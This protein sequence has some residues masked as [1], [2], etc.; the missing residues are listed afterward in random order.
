MAE[1]LRPHRLEV[2]SA[3]SRQ[4][5]RR[6]NKGTSKPPPSL[7]ATVPHHLLDVIE[8]TG[9]FSAAEFARLAKQTAQEIRERGAVPL[10]VGGAMFYVRTLL[11]GPPATPPSDPQVRQRLA[12]RVE[13]EG[14][15]A[16]YDE[17]AVVDPPTAERL[18]QNDR[19]RILRA[20]E[21]YI[22]SGRPL[23]AFAV[24][25]APDAAVA[26][27]VLGVRRDRAD[28]Y[29]RIDERV[30]KMVAGDLVAEI[31]SLVAAGFSADNPG[32]QSIGYAEFFGRSGELRD[33]EALPQ[34]V[35]LIKRNTRRYA[36]RQLTFARS[37]PIQPWV[38]LRPGNE[39]G[40]GDAA[41]AA[42][43]DRL[44]ELSENP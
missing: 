12:V 37:L 33:A 35:A 4:I 41:V 39:A 30:D 32:M 18:H 13:E 11:F 16:I 36:K 8:P 14:I 26:T 25:A 24:P 10:V 23:S 2:I 42:I 44:R 38:D 6:L 7:L 19:N 20:L 27:T 5:Y 29:R 15:A 31:R 34:V 21:V 40:A 28:L 17:L 43:A 1:A 22:V 9:S 3:D